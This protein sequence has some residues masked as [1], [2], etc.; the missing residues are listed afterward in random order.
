M[1]RPPCRMTAAPHRTLPAPAPMKP[2][3]SIQFLAAALLAVLS[4][5]ALSDTVRFASFNASLNRDSTGQLLDDLALP[6]LVDS[7]RAWPDVSGLSVQQRRVLQ[8]HH[9]AEIMQKVRAD[10]LLINEFDFDRDGVATADSAPTPLGYASAAAHLFHDNFLAVPHG[11]ADTGRPGSEPLRY[12]YRYT[13]NTNT[14]VPSGL[15]LD[16]NASVGGGGD[17]LAFGSF[18]GQFGF[19]VY[20]RFEIVNVRSFQNFL[21]KDMPGNLLLNDPTPAPNNLTAFYS[22]AKREVLRLSSKN[23]VDVSLRIN[24]QV[25]HFIVAHPTPPVFDGPE[26]RNG[27]RNHDEIRLLRDYIH[28]ASYLVDDAGQR[29]GLAAGAMFVLAGDFNAD[30]CDGESYR[31]PCTAAGRAGPGPNA[32]GQLLLD[33]LINTSVTPRSAGGTAAAADPDNNGTA[34]QAQ[35][36]DPAFDTADFNDASPGN[37]RVDYVLPSANLKILAAGV[38]WPTPLDSDFALVGSFNKPNLYAGF[39]SSDHRAVWVD[40]RVPVPPLAKP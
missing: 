19:T 24:G 23:H 28:G 39:A 7:S 3:L 30:L 16:N 15:D 6:K 36:G 13:P 9:A 14:G 1:R 20:S 11:G 17:A 8:A 22:P 4:V 35:R 18:A 12:A 25:V 10:V 38:F 34:N 31:A 33:G 29:G 26:D 40:V 5:P 2:T 37:L 27:K 21:W 32:I